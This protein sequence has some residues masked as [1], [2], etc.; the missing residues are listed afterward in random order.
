MVV[1][2]K[3]GLFT[4]VKIFIEPTN[5]VKPLCGSGI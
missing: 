3:S 1:Y 5:Y 2:F 4:V